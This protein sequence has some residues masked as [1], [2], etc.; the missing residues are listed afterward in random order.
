MIILLVMTL[1]GISG[2]EQ[3]TLE[4]RMTLNFRDRTMALNAAESSLHSTEAWLAAQVTKPIPVTA[5]SCTTPPM[6]GL[7]SGY[8]VWDDGALTGWSTQDWTWWSGKGVEYKGSGAVPS[9]L[10]SV[11]AQPRAII[12]FRF[13][14]APSGSGIADNLNAERAMQ[15]IG[16]H[17][18]NIQGAGTG[19]RRET[20]AVVGTTFKKWF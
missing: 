1:I 12:E 18:Y 2:M 16:W 14:N 3:T 4:D 19:H 10:A 8:P 5:T 17:Y 6:C 7:G 15:G 11:S 13:F 20:I 9:K